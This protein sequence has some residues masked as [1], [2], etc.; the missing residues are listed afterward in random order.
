MDQGAV[1]SCRRS[2]AARKRAALSAA[3]A[4]SVPYDLAAGA[5]QQKMIEDIA[6][7]GELLRL[8]GG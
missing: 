7:L 4:V 5:D 6:A 3:V 2:C 1:L 8:V